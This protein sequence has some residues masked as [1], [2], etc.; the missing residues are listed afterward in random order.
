MQKAVVRPTPLHPSLSL[1]SLGF[2]NPLSFDRDPEYSNTEGLAESGK[3][4]HPKKV[5]FS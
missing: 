3:V 5:T 2:A 1:F 4:H